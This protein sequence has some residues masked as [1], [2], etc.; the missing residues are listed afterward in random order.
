MFG[1]EGGGGLNLQNCES[2]VGRWWPTMLTSKQHMSSGRI[3]EMEFIISL[4][5]DNQFLQCTL[6]LS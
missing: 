2:A 4:L 5:L 1:R 3:C 6:A